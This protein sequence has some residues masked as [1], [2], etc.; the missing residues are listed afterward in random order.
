MLELRDYQID[1]TTCVKQ[2]LKDHNK[3]CAILPTGA[4]KTICFIDIAKDYITIYEA[5]RREDL[6]TNIDLNSIYLIRQREK[7]R[8]SGEFTKI[9]VDIAQ[10]LIDKHISIF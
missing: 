2:D 7:T 5:K 6:Y 1:A 8:L 9:F 3:I 10:N 4:G